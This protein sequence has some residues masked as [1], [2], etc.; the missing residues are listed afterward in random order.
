MP[1]FVEQRIDARADFHRMGVD[2]GADARVLLAKGLDRLVWT[3]GHRQWMSISAGVSTFHCSLE[4]RSFVRE[5]QRLRFDTGR[6]LFEG[7]RLSLS[8]LQ[9]VALK[10]IPS[11]AM[12]L[13]HN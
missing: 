7:G 12:G 4:L 10:S 5:Q 13:L 8:R 1:Q 9:T 11:S 6:T 2:F 3:K